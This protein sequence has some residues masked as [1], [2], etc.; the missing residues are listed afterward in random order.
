LLWAEPRVFQ[1]RDGRLAQPPLGG[2]RDR[3]A[4]RAG[5]RRRRS[6]ISR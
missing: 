2:N 1:Q 3:Q 4:V 5:R 6:S